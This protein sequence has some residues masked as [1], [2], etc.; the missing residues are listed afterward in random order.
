MSSSPTAGAFSNLGL[1]SWSPFGLVSEAT[2]VSVMGEIP[3][4]RAAGKMSAGPSSV[5]PPHLSGPQ[6]PHL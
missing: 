1:P 6:S 2:W 4:H 5:T 3:V